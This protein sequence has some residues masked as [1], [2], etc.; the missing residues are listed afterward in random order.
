ML[1]TV[2]KT[3]T[4]QV[5][6]LYAWEGAFQKKLESIRDL[7]LSNI[8]KAAFYMSGS[9]VSLTCAPALVSIKIVHDLK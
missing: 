4:M 5:L 6:K 1:V 2:Q 8:K 7:E 3:F 9:I